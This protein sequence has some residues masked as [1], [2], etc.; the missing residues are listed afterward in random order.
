M[1]DRE[2]EREWTTSENYI[3]SDNAIESCTRSV[4]RIHRNRNNEHSIYLSVCRPEKKAVHLKQQISCETNRTEGN[5]NSTAG[6][7]QGRQINATR[8][9]KGKEKNEVS[10]QRDSPS[11]WRADQSVASLCTTLYG[12]ATTGHKVPSNEGEGGGVWRSAGR[13]R[14]RGAGKGSKC[15]VQKNLN[16]AIHVFQKQIKVRRGLKSEGG[17]KKISCSSR[18]KWR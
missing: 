3:H 1:I 16:R 8:G 18:I 7:W 15:W 5:I 11:D 2:R 10:T 6:A 17:S 13:G 12:F 4:T 14:S 9:T